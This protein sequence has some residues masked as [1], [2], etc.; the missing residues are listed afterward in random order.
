MGFKKIDQIDL[1]S[2]I[3]KNFLGVPLKLIQGEANSRDNRAEIKAIA[4]SSR[5]AS[6]IIIRDESVLEYKHA[7]D[8]SR[9]SLQGNGTITIMNKSNKDRIWDASI[10]FNKSEFNDLIAGIKTPIG[11]LEPSGNYSIKY[12]ITNEANLKDLLAINEHVDVTC[13]GISKSSNAKVSGHP[14][15]TKLLVLGKENRV[16]FTIRV[17][18]NADVRM[19]GVKIKKVLPREFH[20]IKFTG[21]AASNV[22]HSGN[23]IEWAIGSLRPGDDSVLVITAKAQPIGTESIRSGMIEGTCAINGDNHVNM[24]FK[25]FSACSHTNNKISKE[26]KETEPN[27]W[28]CQLSFANHSDFTM[29]IKGISVKDVDQKET[30]IDQRTTEKVPIVVKPGAVY[31]TNMWECVSETEPK[32]LRKLDFSVSSKVERNLTISTFVDDVPLNITGI[33]MTDNLSQAEVKSFEAA[34]V[35]NTVLLKNT[36]NISAFGAV[37]RQKIPAGFLPTD[38]PSDVLV[39][40]ATS[41]ID[42]SIIGIH[43]EPADQ[44]VATDH[45]FEILINQKHGMREF[46]ILPGESLEVRYP[47]KAVRPDQRNAYSFPLET[48]YLYSLYGSTNAPRGEDTVS[49]TCRS[50]KDTESTLKVLHRRR[51]VSVEKEIFPGK[52][53]NEFAIEVVIKNLSNTEVTDVRVVDKVPKSFEIVST[54]GAGEISRS[55]EPDA[56]VISCLIQSLQPYE[57]QVI[58]YYIQNVGGMTVSQTELESYLLG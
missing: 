31:Q 16:D 24:S 13:D 42:Q 19:S 45:Q 57:E 9:R 10:E 27:H 3:S 25:S 38:I 32:F 17:R 50:S 56:V 54:T 22:M 6:E 44:N 23:V 37:I 7:H 58:K 52:N 20:N 43:A 26:E 5:D 18:N 33:Q 55:E 40:K 47:I 29:N 36:G 14:D 28:S 41:P 48:A 46:E 21:D 49:F 35:Y 34:T 4:S 15:E 30:Y 1:N 51:K 39:T 53:S 8:G 12:G 2:K 11:I